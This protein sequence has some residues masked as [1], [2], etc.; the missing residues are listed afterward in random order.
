MRASIYRRYC[1]L[2]PH[3]GYVTQVEY[4]STHVPEHQ[5]SL[6]WTV[7]STEAWHL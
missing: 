2:T 7:T 4:M 3:A 5:G 1:S 6:F